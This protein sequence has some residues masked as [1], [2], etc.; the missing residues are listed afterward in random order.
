MKYL[1]LL[2]IAWFSAFAQSA[3]QQPVIGSAGY[4]SPVPIPV[5]PGQL[6]T[7]FVP[8]MG[9]S[10]TGPVKAP[11]GPLPKLLA[12]VSATFRQL[13]DQPVPILEVQPISTCIGVGGSCGSMLA[14]TV[15]IPFEIQVIC[16]L[17]LSPVLLTNQIA[18]SVNGTL[19]PFVNVTALADQVHF[20]TQCDVVV[21][22]LGNQPNGGLPCPPVVTHADG[23]LVTKTKPAKSGEELVAYA[24]GLGQTNPPL[25]TGQAA[26]GPAPTITAFQIDYNYRWNAGATKP[27]GVGQSPIYAGATPGFAG[28]YQ[29]NFIVP[30]MPT[31][32]PGCADLPTAF[33]YSGVVQSNLT[34][35][36]GSLL[37]F[38][39]IGICVQPGS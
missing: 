31:G 36:M 15:Q 17:C 4:T 5:A 8:A 29:V 10:V 24:T 37:S 19:S 11:P 30:P 1:F 7:L 6:L 2:L 23:T 35:S 39:G 25:T 16:P 14:V 27:T 34:V 13:S 26:S 20:L 22:S 18:V 33:P 32:S 3:V 21:G 12:G 28:L 38:D 9:A